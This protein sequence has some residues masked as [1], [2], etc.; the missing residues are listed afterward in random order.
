MWGQSR[1]CSQ[2]EGCGWQLLTWTQDT[3]KPMAQRAAV[4]TT[5]IGL[6]VPRGQHPEGATK[7]ALASLAVALAPSIEYLRESIPWQLRVAL[8]WH[9]CIPLAG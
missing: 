1:E 9:L 4:I 2:S 7:P 6:P 5:G 3:G 8:G